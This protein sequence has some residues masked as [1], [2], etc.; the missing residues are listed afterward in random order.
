MLI[1]LRSG[2]RPRRAVLACTVLFALFAVL[3][4]VTAPIHPPSATRGSAKPRRDPSPGV[5]SPSAPT[6]VAATGAT[7]DPRNVASWDAVP[8]V[9]ASS[10]PEYPAIAGSDATDATAYAK[11]F[12][13]E[14]F[15]RDYSRSTRA[16]LIA[17]AQYEDSPLRATQY[18]RSDWTKVLVDSLT[19][20]AWEDAAD[21][22]I[23]SAGAWLAFHA[24]RVQEVL[25]AIAVSRDP[26]WERLIAGGYAPPDPLAVERDVSIV[27]VVHRVLAGRLSTSRLSVSVKLQLGSSPRRPGYAIAAANDFLVNAEP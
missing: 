27:L 6:K 5:R 15:T 3:A 25:G 2:M 1:Q 10:S 18:P 17:W 8:P 9:A 26:T 7:A 12:A 13:T 14:L 24:Q 4:L 21:T 19:D 22:P 20:P 16:Q 23:P 11:A